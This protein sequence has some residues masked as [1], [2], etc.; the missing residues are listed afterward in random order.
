MYEIKEPKNFQYKLN[1]KTYNIIV[2]KYYPI[3]ID[4]GQSESIKSQLGS[5]DVY[6]FLT[7]FCVSEKGERP[8]MKNNKIIFSYNLHTSVKTKISAMLKDILLY[9]D[10]DEEELPYKEWLNVKN[11]VSD[12]LLRK[13]FIKQYS[14]TVDQKIQT[15]RFV[16]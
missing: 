6:Q 13:Y 16:I 2:K 12:Y 7:D 1:G 11:V 5:Q 4:F 15:I 14:K 9:F 10:Q 8:N 3:I